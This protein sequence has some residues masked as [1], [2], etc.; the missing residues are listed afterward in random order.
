MMDPI[1]PGNDGWLLL[2]LVGSPGLLVV[3]F[4]M[5]LGRGRKH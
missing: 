5:F 3:G 2:G 1:G 4:F